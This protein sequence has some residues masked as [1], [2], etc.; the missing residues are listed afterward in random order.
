MIVYALAGAKL[1]GTVLILGSLVFYYFGA[2]WFDT[3]LLA[4]VIAINFFIAGA[5]EM[6]SGGTRKFLLVFVL[7]FLLAL[8]FE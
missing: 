5:I 1:R 8:E 2:G 6:N 7:V 3:T 4:A